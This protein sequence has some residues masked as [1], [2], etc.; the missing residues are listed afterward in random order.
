M[1]FGGYHTSYYSVIG[2]ELQVSCEV[3]QQDASVLLIKLP[4]K[5]I[6]G[7]HKGNH[8]KSQ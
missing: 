3:D 8:K 6:Y 7:N 1:N 5:K 4:S 2:P